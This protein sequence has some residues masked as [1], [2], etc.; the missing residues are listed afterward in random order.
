[1]SA[2]VVLRRGLAGAAILLS[3]CLLLA[4]CST[5]SG[6]TRS[7]SAS[8]LEKEPSGAAA[9]PPSASGA[10]PGQDAASGVSA[11]SG[12]ARDTAALAPSGQ[13]IIYTASLTFRATSVTTAAQRAIGI[14]ELAGGYVASEHE[15][16]GGGH[17]RASVSLTLKIPVAAYRATLSRLSGP[18]LGQ[19]L[20]MQQ[21]ATDVTQQVADVNSLVTSQQDAIS[22]LQGLLKK[23]GSV[24]GLLQVQQQISTDE[25][26]LNSLEAQ[27]RALDHQTSYAT[28][29]M[30]LQSPKVAVRSAQA[31]HHSFLTGLTAG[32]RALRHAT[33]WV[34]TAIGALL[35]FL[36]IL[37]LLG[38]LGY[39]G[40]RRYGRNRPRPTTPAA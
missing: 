12:H 5:G 18:A 40:W 33:S 39:A 29:S 13:S 30:T 4:S 23:A 21:R 2:L 15:T 7:S 11:A 38:G 35:P 22:A 20:A 24:G 26:E 3:G 37:A 17:R 8:G 9:V 28:V 1:M 34:L 32:W 14:A 25:S 36:I 19:R 31:H 6:D 16:S 27:Q 10:G